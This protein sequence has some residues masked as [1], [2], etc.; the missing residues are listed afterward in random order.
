[1][2]NTRNLRRG[3]PSRFYSIRYCPLSRSSVSVIVEIK[4]GCNELFM[5]KLTISLISIA[6]YYSEG[7][8]ERKR[9]EREREKVRNRERERQRE[10][11]RDRERQ[12]D[13][14]VFS[15]KQFDSC[16]QFLVFHEY[17]DAPSAKKKHFYNFKHY[18]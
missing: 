16:N 12:R 4:V 11:E 8:M 5:V 2:T 13:D 14:Q 3:T 9:G 7:D 1:M 17:H 6:L 10:T 15:I 18:P